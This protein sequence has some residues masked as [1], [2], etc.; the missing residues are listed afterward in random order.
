[1]VE[2]TNWVKVDPETLKVHVAK[3]V[4]KELDA[5]IETGKLHVLPCGYHKLLDQERHTT[6]PFKEKGKFAQVPFKV[7]FDGEQVVTGLDPIGR[8]NIRPSVVLPAGMPRATTYPLIAGKN[9]VG[10][11]IVIGKAGGS[12]E[13]IS[14]SIFLWC[15][16]N[17]S[18]VPITCDIEVSRNGGTAPADWTTIA[19]RTFTNS[20]NFLNTVVNTSGIV[21]GLDSIPQDY[22]FV[23]VALINAGAGNVWNIAIQGGEILYRWKE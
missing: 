7:T 14:A 10:R 20:L 5:L 19:T 15:D 17:A 2:K 9:E 6:T 23:R 3:A 1:M 8:I 22:M 12:I 21:T 18:P 11:W 13:S 4:K 16:N